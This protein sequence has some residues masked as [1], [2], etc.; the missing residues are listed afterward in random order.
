MAPVMLGTKEFR[1]N[2]EEI[3]AVNCGVTFADCTA[4]AARMKTGEISRVKILDLVR[5]FFCFACAVVLRVL[6]AAVAVRER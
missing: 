6:C 1:A 5:F 2:F 3:D 4:L